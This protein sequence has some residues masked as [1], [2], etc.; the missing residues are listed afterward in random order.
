MKRIIVETATRIVAITIVL[1]AFVSAIWFS[2][3]SNNDSKSTVEE[4]ADCGL[5]IEV[6]D[7]LIT[8]QTQNG[9]VFTF[10]C[11]DETFYVGDLVATIMCDNGTQEVFDDI[12]VGSRYVGWIDNEYINEWV[13]VR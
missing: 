8:Y 2:A 3:K 7:S 5:V 13:K 10:L 12:V 4:Y 6:N 9:N 11:E 1:L